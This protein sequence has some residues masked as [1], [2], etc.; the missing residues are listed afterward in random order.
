MKKR[1]FV[2][3]LLVLICI[4][5]LVITN[6]NNKEKKKQS[7]KKVVEKINSELKKELNIN[8]ELIT[9]N[10]YCELDN[11]FINGCLYSKN[12]IKKEELSIKYRIFSILMQIE[13]KEKIETTKKF[14]DKEYEINYKVDSNKIK[15]IYKNIYNDDNYQPQEINNI[16]DEQKIIYEN[17]TFYYIKQESIDANHVITYINKYEKKKN[18]I[19]LYVS[20]AFVNLV[21]NQK[22]EITNYE[23]YEDYKTMNLKEEGSYDEYKDKKGKII[24][25]LNKDNYKTYDEYKVS[26][27]KENEKYYF[28]KIEL[29]D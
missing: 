14:R 3:V 11:K 13:E 6:T 5:Y 28:E 16:E 9:S 29:L 10:G 7:K 19:Y 2:V 8:F 17:N 26:F 21:Q 20:T 24:F 15:E 22:R 27:K 23:I 1:T 25:K 18:H 12:K 4:I